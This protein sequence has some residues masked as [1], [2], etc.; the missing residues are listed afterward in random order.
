MGIEAIWA[1]HEPNAWIV[2][3]QGAEKNAAASLMR[4]G[5]QGG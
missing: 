2:E 3:I 1:N 4:A 5:F